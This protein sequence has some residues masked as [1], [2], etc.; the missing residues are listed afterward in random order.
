MYQHHGKK[1][2]SLKE[3]SRDGDIEY[4]VQADAGKFVIE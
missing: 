4:G 2:K 3:G 1:T